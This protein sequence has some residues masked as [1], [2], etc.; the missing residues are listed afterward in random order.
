MAF[1]LCSNHDGGRGRGRGGYRGRGH[2]MSGSSDGGGQSRFK[3]SYSEEVREQVDLLYNK[4]FK[5]VDEYNQWMLPDLTSWF[6]QNEKEPF[7]VEAL[8]EVKQQLKEVKSR[9]DG[10]EITSWLKHTSFANRAGV[11][12]PAVRRDYEPE[13]CTQVHVCE[14]EGERR[15]GEKGEAGGGRYMWRGIF[16]CALEEGIYEGG[17][18]CMDEEKRVQ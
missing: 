6:N 9:L 14:E 12:V 18:M 3:K 1:Y 15:E 2:G 11:V 4:K 10:V 13:M 7:Q 16:L 17:N 8:L 5:F